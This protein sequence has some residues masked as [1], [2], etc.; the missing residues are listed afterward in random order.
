MEVLLHF[1]QIEELSFE[2]GGINMDGDLISIY[3]PIDKESIKSLIIEVRDYRVILDKDVASCFGVETGALNRAMKRNILRFPER[4][5]FQLTA[6]ECSRCQIGI[7]NSG[8]G[9][10]LKYLPY[11]YTEQGVA[12]LTSVLHTERAIEASIKIMEAFVEMTHLLNQN[13]W[14]I[15]KEE[16]IRM[17]ANEISAIKANM[18][19]KKDLEAIMEIFD[20]GLKN[21][22]VLI[23]DGEPF[24]ADIAYQRIYREA[25]SDIIMIDEYLGLKTLQKLSHADEAIDITIISNNR[26]SNPLRKVEFADFMVEYPKRKISFI[27]SQNKIHD[28]YIILDYKIGKMKVFLCGSSSKDSG[29]RITTITRLNS[30][31]VYKELLDKLL[32]NPKL[33]LK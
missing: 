12:M 23:L 27:R 7:L 15:P 17:L 6:E 1:L 31:E 30:V 33:V 9:T 4:F 24:K 20:S 5:C 22:E 25:Q 11:A 14:I 3:N 29:K 18:V 32:A 19:R 16:E 10:N 13:R 8:R 2:Y 26:G 21:E 28:R